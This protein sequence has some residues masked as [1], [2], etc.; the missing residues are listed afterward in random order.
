MMNRITIILIYHCIIVIYHC[1]T[2]I[3][4]ECP[5][6]ACLHYITSDIGPS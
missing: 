2:E 5:V 1:A 4:E 6:L 3:T